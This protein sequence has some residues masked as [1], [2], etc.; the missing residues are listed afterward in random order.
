MPGIALRLSLVLTYLEWASG[1]EGTEPYE[2]TPEA[3]QKAIKL[4]D[5]YLTPMAEQAFGIAAKTDGEQNTI[6]LANWIRETRRTRIT[7]RDVQRSG[8]F[9]ANI[10]ADEI[11]AAC[12]ALT[13]R[14]W[15]KLDYA[16]Q[17]ENGGRKQTAFL[18]NPCL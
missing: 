18:V 4:I 12:L 5:H 1:H 6:T 14:K 2:I 15:L 11:K 7:V 3:I 17:G 8:P 16:R 13:A 10:K 9:P